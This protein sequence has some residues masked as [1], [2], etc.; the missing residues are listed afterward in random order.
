MRTKL[1]LLRRRIGG[2]WKSS[3]RR[4][5]KKRKFE[6]KMRIKGG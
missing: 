3:R 5:R 1:R 4:N 6:R 2:R